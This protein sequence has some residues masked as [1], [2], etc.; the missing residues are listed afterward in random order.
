[1]AD[2]VAEVGDDGSWRLQSLEPG[3][4]RKMGKNQIDGLVL[5]DYLL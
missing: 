1:L 2:F 5:L 4:K 3:N